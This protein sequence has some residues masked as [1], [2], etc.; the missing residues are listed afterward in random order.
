MKHL[1][2]F[3]STKR[4][5]RAIHWTPDRLFPTI[6]PLSTPKEHVN[7]AAITKG[8]SR[9][10]TDKILHYLYLVTCFAHEWGLFSQPDNHNLDSCELSLSFPPPP[11][12]PPP[13]LHGQ[14]SSCIKSVQLSISSLR[15]R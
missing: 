1:Y 14:T 13:N 4:A 9:L 7:G 2:N 5:K 3:K 6:A 12:P 15:Y 10:L 11:P 8:A